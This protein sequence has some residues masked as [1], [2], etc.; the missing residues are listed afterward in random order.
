MW[1]ILQT[2][3][4]SIFFIAIIH[5]L[6]LFFMNNLTTPIVKDLVHSPSNKYDQMFHII[7]SNSRTNLNSNSNSNSNSS[8]GTHINDLKYNLSD[9]I[10]NDSN[11]APNLAPNMKDELKSFLQEQLNN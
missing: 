11:L 7:N 6:Y 10:P 2:I 8:S 4:F 9:L 5:Y 3:L 1:W